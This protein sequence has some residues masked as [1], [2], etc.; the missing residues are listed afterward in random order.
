MGLTPSCLF[1]LF[2]RLR[3]ILYN[4]SMAGFS[5]Q[6]FLENKK[7]LFFFFLSAGLLVYANSLRNPFILDDV[8]IITENRVIQDPPDWAFAFKYDMYGQKISGNVEFFRPLPF[9]SLYLDRLVSGDSPVFYRLHGVLLHSVSSFLLFFVFLGGGLDRR[10][11]FFS[12][13][14]WLVHPASAQ[15]AA[16]ISDRAV[17]LAAFFSFLSFISFRRG[18]MPLC[19]LF[20]LFALL[21]KETAVVLPFVLLFY[22]SVFG[23]RGSVLKGREI[24]TLLFLAAVSGVYSCFR[25]YL[26]GKADMVPLSF[27]SGEPFHVRLLTFVREMA[28]YFRLSLLPVNPA[29]EN[30]FVERVF[31]NPYNSFFTAAT[32]FLAFLYFRSRDFFLQ[33]VFWLFWFFSWLFPVSNLFLP[34]SASMRLQW[35]Y[36]PAA[37]V[38]AVLA[39]S[40]SRFAGGSRVAARLPPLLLAA[41]FSLLLFQTFKRNALASDPV[42]FFSYEVSAEPNNYVA[43]CYLGLESFKRGDYVGAKKYFQESLDRSPRKSYEPAATNLKII[44]QWLKNPSKLQK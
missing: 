28:L 42:K 3:Q 33:M 5:F 6:N 30:H 29:F 24:G 38:I 21:S 25:F 12:A 2:R 9:I 23:R 32:V 31:F 18:M 14:A 27:L 34:L 13:L 39:M 10:V 22:H 26:Q 44:E 7:L 1:W 20:S 40:F 15:A 41:W 43:W 19:A 4:F 37:G 16:Y 8:A 35:L 11:A 17:V 36:L